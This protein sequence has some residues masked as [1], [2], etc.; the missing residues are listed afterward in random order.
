MS[1]ARILIVEDEPML[2]EA[3]RMMLED[4]GYTVEEA[5]TGAE[6]RAAVRAQAPD[7]ILLDLGLPDVSG[8]DLARE[9]SGNPDTAGVAIL[10]LTGRVGSEERKACLAAGCKAYFAKP[11]S[12]KELLR[13][14]PEFL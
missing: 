4:S 14:L 9:L 7:L 8:L 2:R 11:L 12:P 1:G 10:A 6:A 5:G 3:F 13:R